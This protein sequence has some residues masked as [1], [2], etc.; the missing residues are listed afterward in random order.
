M[1]SLKRLTAAGLL[2]FLAA[3]AST[4]GPPVPNKKP[5]TT[6]ASKK[7]RAKTAQQ[8]RSKPS[9]Q[10]TTSG[11]NNL[12]AGF[13]VE[14]ELRTCKG[15]T[16]SNAPPTDS[17]RHLLGYKPTAKVN[18]VTLLA[19]PAPK[20]CLSSAFGYRRGKLHK[21]VDLQ[22]RP[23]GPVVAA[24]A[25]TIVEAKTRSDYGRYLLIDH[26]RGVFTR[27]AHLASYARGVR[28]GATV[29]M[30]TRLG[31]MGNSAGYAIPIHLHYEVLTGNYDTPKG[32]FG[33]KPINILAIA[34]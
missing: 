9:G 24:G 30:G 32:A 21:G 33:L 8:R 2:A 4:G 28:E 6:E 3:C 18:G 20:A 22:S 10:R 27:Y 12:A 15:L 34:R 1:G 5:Q 31:I 11:D 16:V 29:K 19:A 13:V 25:G 7:K 26:G 14:R 17:E 23:A